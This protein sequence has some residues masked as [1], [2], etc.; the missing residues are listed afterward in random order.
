MLW[1]LML[2]CFQ[3]MEGYWL[4]HIRP[5][6]TEDFAKGINKGILDIFKT[7]I[8]IN[9]ANWSD[10]TTERIKLPVIMK[11]YGLR[12]AEDRQYGQFIGAILLLELVDSM[13]PRIYRGHES[14]V[15]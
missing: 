1:I 2:V 9:T 6:F 13:C 11:G 12:E 4:R 7:I 8:G 15:S 10:H 3:I 5:D 14:Q